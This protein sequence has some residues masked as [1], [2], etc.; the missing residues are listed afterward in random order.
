MTRTSLTFLAEGNPETPDSWSGISVR[1]VQ[2]LRALGHRVNSADCDLNGVGKVV[3]A[4]TSWSPDRARWWVRYHLGH[5]AFRFRSARA[6]S[7]IASYP[8]DVVVQVGATF[9]PRLRPAQR[10]V[11]LTDG[12]IVLSEAAAGSAAADAAFLSAS[13]RLAVRA[14]EARVYARADLVVTLSRR[15]AESAVQDFGVPVDRTVTMFAGPNLELDRI[16]AVAGVPAGVPPTILF[17]GKQFARKG[18]DL[19][20]RAFAR[21]REMVP[22]ARLQIIGPPAPAQV[23]RGVEFLGTIDK[24]QPE[25]WAR[26]CRAYAEATVFCL[27]SRYEGFAISVLEAMLFARPTVTLRLPWMRSEMVEDGVTGY[28]VEGEDE[29]A[30]VA[31][32]VEL[33]R[34]PEKVLTMGAAARQRVLEHYTWPLAVGRLSTAIEEL[35]ASTRQERPA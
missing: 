21:V 22:E 19:L 26:I 16:H 13:E 10:L 11:V 33:L 1:V 7:A 25:G 28:A 35:A 14:R 3:A 18:G 6:D 15:I 32:L 2:E 5:T 20:L 34:S 30:L 8:S 23:P 9:L 24:S 4:A 29:E 27:P 17:V 31:R 12:N